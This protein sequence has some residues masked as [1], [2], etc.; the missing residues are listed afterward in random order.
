MSTTISTI[1]VLIGFTLLTVGAWK[2]INLIPLTLLVSALIGFT[3]G[4]NVGEVWSG[5]YMEGFIGFAGKYLLLFCFGALFG[6]IL[7]DRSKLEDINVVVKSR[8]QMGTG[9]LCR[10]SHS[11][12]YGGV[13]SLLSSSFASDRKRHF[14]NLRVPWSFSPAY[15]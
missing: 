3:G 6:K 5:L 15:Q 2:K 8:R 1:G 9:S 4:L 7:E 10:N 14:K 11:L 13:V 12:I